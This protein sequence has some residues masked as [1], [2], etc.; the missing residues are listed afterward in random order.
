VYKRQEYILHLKASN[1]RASKWAEPGHLVAWEEIILQS[2]SFD[3]SD[4]NASQQV[5]LTNHN[6]QLEIVF[7]DGSLNF[8]MESGQIIELNRGKT[9]II[10]G[11][12][13]LS[14]ARAYI[15]NDKIKPMRMQW[16][17]ID[18]H[19]L[20]SIVTDL[21]VE[22][23]NN[24][25]VIYVTKKHQAPEHINGFLSNEIFKI[26][27]NGII[28]IQA[29]I[30]YIG[31]KVPQTLPRIGYEIKVNSSITESKWYGKGPGSS[32]KDRNIGMQIGLYSANIDEHFINYARP[33][34]NGNKSDVRWV[35]VYN[36][37]SEGLKLT[38]RQ[39]INFSFRKYTTK[40]LNEA[41]HPYDLKSNAFNILNIDFEQGAVGNGSC[42]PMPMQKCYTTINPQGYHLRLEPLE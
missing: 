24:Q 27:G 7:N 9:R 13:A 17:A 21:K 36:N 3:L 31:T 28:D 41:E 33:Q 5:K 1:I 42:G 10:D 40:Q 8:D 30:E 18:L 34:E 12:M 14:F 35:K 15:D 11:A 16:D 32:Y 20:V 29:M 2:P 25:V 37:L 19:N 26:N 39:P 23:E 4:V 6:S 22:E 38:G